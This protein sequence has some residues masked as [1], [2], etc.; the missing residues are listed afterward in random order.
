MSTYDYVTVSG[1][2]QIKVEDLRPVS[3]LHTQMLTLFATNFPTKHFD[4]F[5]LFIK[6]VSRTVDVFV[7]GTDHLGYSGQVPVPTVLLDDACDL[8]RV[9]A[10]A[11][12]ELQSEP[13]TI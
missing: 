13:S 2:I 5:R 7:N 9:K 3:I 11:D 10:D 8:S 12:A 6:S 4:S 1:K